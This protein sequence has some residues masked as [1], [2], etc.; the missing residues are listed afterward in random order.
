MTYSLTRNKRFRRSYIQMH[1][2]IRLALLYIGKE[3]F[4][5]SPLGSSQE[6]SIYSGISLIQFSWVPNRGTRQK[7]YH[8]KHTQKVINDAY[9]AWNLVLLGNF[10]ITHNFTLWGNHLKKESITFY[11]QLPLYDAHGDIKTLLMK[12]TSNKTKIVK[13]ACFLAMKLNRNDG[14]TYKKNMSPPYDFFISKLHN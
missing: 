2:K 7:S 9:S 4:C 13:T 6:Y 14:F 12:W 1:Y 8:P 3:T 10:R 11:S 5:T